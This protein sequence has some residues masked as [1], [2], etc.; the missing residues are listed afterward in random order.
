MVL[1][2]THLMVGFLLVI[3][4][5]LCIAWLAYGGSSFG[6]VGVA[7]P[8]VFNVVYVIV[9]N[10]QQTDGFF[11]NNGTTTNRTE[12]IGRVVVNSVRNNSMSIQSQ[13]PSQY[14]IIGT[15]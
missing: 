10:G 4:N 14:I 9:G 11:T 12:S 1:V 6:V 3:N 2:Q 15:N 5:T 8:I 13:N 7:F